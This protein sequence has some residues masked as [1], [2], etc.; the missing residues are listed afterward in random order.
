M[1]CAQHQVGR[2]GWVA[3]RVAHPWPPPTLSCLLQA[4]LSIPSLHTPHLQAPSVDQLA[5]P[6]ADNGVEVDQP[7]GFPRQLRAHI[8]GAVRKW[9]LQSGTV[10][11]P[12][13]VWI[14]HLGAE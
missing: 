4:S 14:G 11:V 3:C 13:V 5:I 6:V 7:G 8:A 1:H 9:P 12:T 10:A 2:D